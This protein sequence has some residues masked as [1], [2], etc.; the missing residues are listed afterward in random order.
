MASD[1]RNR[2]EKILLIDLDD[3][4]RETRVRLLQAGGYEVALRLNWLTAEELNH[5]K[6][7]DLLLLA[8]HRSDLKAAAAYSDRLV[9]KY[10]T[11]PILLLAD[12]N[13]YAPKGTLSKSMQ[14]GNPRDLMKNIAAMLANSS[15]IYELTVSLD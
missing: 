13:V 8:L 10:P 14:T 3:T 9:A 5:E 15:H 2:K 1:Q 11:L 7:H 6:D 4:R 12:A